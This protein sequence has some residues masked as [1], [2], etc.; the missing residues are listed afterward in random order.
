MDQESY[1][2][3]KIFTVQ[4]KQVSCS[5]FDRLNNGLFS[6]RLVKMKGSKLGFLFF[7]ILDIRKLEEQCN[8]FY[9]QNWLQTSREIEIII[10]SFIQKFSLHWPTLR[11]MHFSYRQLSIN[12]G[13]SYFSLRQPQQ[14]QFISQNKG[15]CRDRQSRNGTSNNCFFKLLLQLG[16]FVCLLLFP[17]F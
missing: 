9:R 11:P 4:L 1:F 14:K 8:Q 6:F 17:L 7:R 10:H 13:V 15:Q 16:C 3:Q 12:S 5:C 2:P